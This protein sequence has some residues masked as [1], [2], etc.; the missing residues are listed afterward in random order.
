MKKFNLFD[1]IITAN[2]ADILNAINKNEIFGINIAGEILSQPFNNKEV[3]IYKDK[4]E[5]QNQ[6]GL[7]QTKPQTL[8]GMFGKNYQIVEPLEPCFHPISSSST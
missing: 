6:T 8:Q 5:I 7:T 1:E 4:I 2:K 3:F